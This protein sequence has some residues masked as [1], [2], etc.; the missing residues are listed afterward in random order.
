MVTDFVEGHLHGEISLADMASVA[1]LSRFHFSRAFK[2]TTGE[3]PYAFVQRRRIARAS[4]LLKNS[5]L[6]IDAIAS[7]VG[8]NGSM[9]FARAFREIMGMPPSKYRVMR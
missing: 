7:S 9:Q 1:G 4:S 2:A 8:F 5:P 6:P 3:S